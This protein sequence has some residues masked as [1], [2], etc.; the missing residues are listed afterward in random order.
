MSQLTF[1]L[2]NNFYDCFSFTSIRVVLPRLSLIHFT[3]VNLSCPKRLPNQDPDNFPH[4]YLQEINFFV[5]CFDT[6]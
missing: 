2:P 3:D 4:G 6:S 1:L 5:F